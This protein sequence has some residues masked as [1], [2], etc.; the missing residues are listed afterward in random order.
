MADSVLFP[1]KPRSDSS[2][3]GQPRLAT[4]QCQHS[5]ST[6]NVFFSIK[7]IF[8]NRDGITEKLEEGLY[9]EQ[10]LV[11]ASPWLGD[12]APTKPE[13]AAKK[14]GQG[15][16]LDLKSGDGKPP[17]LWVVR[18][19]SGDAWTSEIVPGRETRKLLKAAGNATP[20]EVAVSAVTR[21][22]REGE[23]VKVRVE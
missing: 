7:C 5:K 22:G 2:E 6:G 12:E 19:R 9:K 15:V 21:L 10:A 13:V 16:A 4:L 3:R 20:E 18:T 14:N 11:P 17:W 1:L 23:V 8:D